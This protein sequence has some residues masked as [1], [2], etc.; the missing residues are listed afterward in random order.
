MNTTQ[1]P[2]TNVSNKLKRDLEKHGY[3]VLVDEQKE[4]GKL[5][6]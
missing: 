4:K 3:G 2:F 1:S 5:H 6:L